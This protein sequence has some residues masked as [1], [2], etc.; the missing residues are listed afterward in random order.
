M[1]GIEFDFGVHGMSSPDLHPRHLPVLIEVTSKTSVGVSDLL[2]E[3]A[4]ALQ[5]FETASVHLSFNYLPLRID[6]ADRR[7]ILDKLLPVASA[8]NS[9]RPAEIVEHTYS[10]R[11]N[12][13]DITVQIQV[14][15]V[16]SLGVPGSKVTLDTHND[17]LIPVMLLLERRISDVLGN[18][19]KRRQAESGNVVLI[20]D[21]A[22]LAGTFLRPLETWQQ[23]L[24]RIVQDSAPFAA[25][26]IAASD[27]ESPSMPIV[28]ATRDTAD[29]E[30][31][32]A[33]EQLFRDILQ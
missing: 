21:I 11:R 8:V 18:T 24:E 25:I 30:V 12:P 27:L 1:A 19:K 26:A 17:D 4:I 2:E 16:L 28:Y 3:V 29:A 31:R 23:F 6:E 15:P 32:A 20:I 13:G 33:I 14:M 9:G 7:A 10:D 22:H 5:P